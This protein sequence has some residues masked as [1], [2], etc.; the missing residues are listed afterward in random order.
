MYSR[1]AAASSPLYSHNSIDSPG[2]NSNLMGAGSGPS[3]NMGMPVPG[4][5]GVLGPP[6]SRPARYRRLSADATA[7]RQ[8][9]MMQAAGVPQPEMSADLVGGVANVL[10]GG[11]LPS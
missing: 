10:G 11:T 6:P 7:V 1:P 4:P 2:N 8:M 3:S 5:D 9:A